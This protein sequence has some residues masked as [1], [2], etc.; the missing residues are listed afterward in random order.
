VLLA[1]AHGAAAQ[2][3]TPLT[4]ELVD[5]RIA[6]LRAAGTPSD[7]VF[8]NFGE[9]SLELSARCFLDSVDQRL[10]VMTELRT[11]INRAFQ[12]AGITIAFPQR[13]VHIDAGGPIRVAIEP[14]PGAEKRAQTEPLAKGVREA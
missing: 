11:A 14:A 9:N 10:T 13:D 1:V 8:E 12:D 7:N 3:S 5:Q 2:P 6:V 4:I